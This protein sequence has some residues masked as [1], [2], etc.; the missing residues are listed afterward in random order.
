MAIIQYSDLD[1]AMV[2]DAQG[3]VKHVY[4]AQAIGASIK[5]FILTSPGDRF[6]EP[7]F[8]FGISNY[9]FSLS[10]KGEFDRLASRMKSQVESFEPRAKIKNITVSI[11]PDTNEATINLSYTPLGSN[12]IQAISVD[13]SGV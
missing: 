6:M 11:D 5:N 1:P 9:I 4:N 8:G 13:V 7:W 2:T 10:T 3:N 12:E